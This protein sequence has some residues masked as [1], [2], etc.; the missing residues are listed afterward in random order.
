[1]VTERKS[2]YVWVTW[3]TKLLVGESSCEWATW[4][5][6]HYRDYE[7]VPSGFNAT[8]WQLKH[9]SALN[10]LRERIEASGVTV[11]TESQNHFSLRGSTATLGGRPDLIARSGTIGTIY[12]V[13]TGRPSPSHS[14]QVMVYMYAVPRALK[15]HQAVTFDGV[16]VY[17]DH[18]VEVPSSAIDAAFVT[19]LSQ[20][21]RRVAGSVPARRVPSQMECRFCPITDKDCSDRAANK[22]SSVGETQDF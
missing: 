15:Q 3:L 22:L 1:M 16:V 10:G 19:V 8:E 6:A 12:D 20:L 9:R 2:L 11:F 4:F 13:K 21:I 7:G 14:V 5:K 18:E 17:G